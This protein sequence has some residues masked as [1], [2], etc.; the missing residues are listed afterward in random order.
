MA[1]PDRQRWILKSVVDTYVSTAEPVGS[2]TIAAQAEQPI[3]SATVRNEMAEL[4]A[5]GYLEQ[6]H[7]SAGRVPTDK[8]YRVYV[9]R[10][11][12]PE[13]IPEAE[14]QEIR[15]ELSERIYEVN[16]LLKRATHLLS[17]STGYA[18]V[19]LT[20]TEKESFVSQLK[21]LQ[22]EPGRVMVIVVLSA[23]LVKDRII[24]TS[25]MLN[26]E[27]LRLIAVALEENLKGVPLKDITLVTVESAAEGI[28]LPDAI[29][30]QLL[31]EAYVS[32][33]QAEN[34]D[35]YMDGMQRLL[36]Q[37]EFHKPAEVHKVYNTL[38]K[39]G[40]ITGYLSRGQAEAEEPFMIRIGQEITL[41]GLEAC[42]L[43]TTTY[44][45][46]EKLLGRIGIIGP[47]RMD[48]EKVIP[49]IGFIR[50]SVKEI[51]DEKADSRNSEQIRNA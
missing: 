51:Y 7:T 25:D 40:L 9:D 30:N 50:E 39:D 15:G 18:S 29:L 5:E 49:R 33:K 16:D 44:Q 32:I 23:G 22:I 4:E 8:A 11:M 12:T 27:Q 41:E 21:F 43:V 37:P 26:S 45:L 6:P 36:I 14:K 20:P 35:V 48:Y 2:K 31:Y 46:G 47:R 19:T 1:L 10:L 17:E 28:K 24:R 42:S 38:H 34:L 3:S 13:P